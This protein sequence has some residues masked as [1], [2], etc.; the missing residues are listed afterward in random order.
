MSNQSEIEMSKWD[1]ET[2]SKDEHWPFEISPPDT[3]TFDVISVGHAVVDIMI[4][5][6]DEQL[7]L[8]TNSK[9][10]MQLADSPKIGEE[11]VSKLITANSDLEITRTSGGSAGNTTYTLAKLGLRVGF[12]GTVLNDEL[13][14]LYV[15]GLRDSSVTCFFEP[16][17]VDE[18]LT[19]ETSSLE[20]IP[21]LATGRCNVFITPDKDR[22]MLTYLGASSYF[23]LQDIDN[24]D[25]S[26]SQMLYLEGYLFDSKNG[27]GVLMKSVDIANI[28]GTIVSLSLSDPFV[29][30]RYKDLIAELIEDRKITLLFGNLSEAQILCGYDELPKIVEYFS[31]KRQLAVITNGSKGSY[32]IYDNKVCYCPAIDTVDV[33]DTTGAGDIFASGVIFGCLRGYAIS[34]SLELGTLL[35]KEVIEHIGPRPASNPELLVKQAGFEV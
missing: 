31:D 2:L 34:K 21:D 9:G 23:D 22:T 30:E 14:N 27:A 3:K 35:A 16:K 26:Q 8:I 12:L 15:N 18:I 24:L 20:A 28:T 1:I 32:C 33:V 17:E 10:T 29:V 4:N 13:G 6:T 19:I 11:F 25:I 5:T 7:S